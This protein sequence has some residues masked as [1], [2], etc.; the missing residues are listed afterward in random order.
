MIMAL[1]IVQIVEVVDVI[2]VYFK[3][4]SHFE[5][6]L[7][8]DLS[9]PLG[10]EVIHN[11]F[12]HSNFY[13]LTACLLK[14]NAHAIGSRE[15]IKVRQFFTGKRKSYCVDKTRL[16]CLDVLVNRS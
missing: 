14:Q 12:C 8:V 2:Y 15:S 3:L 9:D 7:N 6:V 13:P 11:Y 10:I 4:L 1:V 16:R 5:V